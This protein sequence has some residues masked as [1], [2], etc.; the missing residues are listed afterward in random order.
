MISLYRI[1]IYGLQGIKRNLWVSTV[2]VFALMVT[3]GAL[4]ATTVSDAALQSRLKDLRERLSYVIFLN[5]SASEAEIEIM[6]TQIAQ[7][8]GVATVG[9]VT[10]QEAFEKFRKDIGSKSDILKEFTPDNNPFPR[11]LAVRFSDLDSVDTFNGFVLE[12]FDPLIFDTSYT[13]NQD[14]IGSLLSWSRTVR[15]A[16]WVV[17]AFFSLYAVS[18]LF[19]T[20]R[21][22]IFARREEVDIM[23]LVGATRSFIRGPFLVEG[24]ILGLI[25]ALLTV[26]FTYI[27][28]YQLP[29]LLNQNGSVDSAQQSQF[30]YQMTRVVSYL[31]DGSGALASFG[32]I[33]MLQIGM[34]LV[35][36]VATSAAAIKRYLRH[37]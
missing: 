23:R 27:I 36:S 34:G 30:S 4:T 10:K 1:I 16:G 9:Y 20:V 31:R 26:L 11:E 25:G 32:Q 35:L 12:K 8:P 22:A 6:R 7:Q 19:N 2:T 24:V 18:T 15:F 21:L 13:K 17:I 33:V 5:D 37:G 3:L 28:L 29:G 14:A